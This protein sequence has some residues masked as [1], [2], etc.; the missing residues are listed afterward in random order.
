[1][2]EHVLHCAGCNVRFR[3]KTYDPTKKYRCSKCKGVLKPDSS[4]TEAPD[5]QSLVSKPGEAPEPVDDKLVGQRISHYRLI[6]KLGQGGMGAVYQAENVNLKRTVALKI[7]PPEL[8]AANPQYAQ[9]FLR[10][11]QSQAALDHPNVV[12]IHHVGK[13]GDYYY[14][15]M[16]YVTGGNLAD[17][18]K[19]DHAVEVDRAVEIVRGAAA[20]L[21]AAHEEG[22]VHRDVKPENILLGKGDAP[23]V[24]DF[25]LAKQVE[26]ESGLTQS[27]TVLGTPYYMSPEQ[28]EA[29]PVDAR[30][31]IYSLG[32]TLYHLLTG[33]QPFRAGSAV[34]IMYKHCEEA[35][36]A[37]TKQSQ[38][39]FFMRLLRC[40]TAP[41]NE[42][43]LYKL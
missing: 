13:E 20:G 4:A 19:G 16:Q 34:A 29:K 9:R 11:A 25:G 32:V 24:S 17:L 3:V 42:F 35:P 33:Q 5:A 37:P 2:A 22:L 14:I 8:S 30:S 43:G 7:L 27:G 26:L 31:D 41:R 36:K 15:E 6:K 23:K 39:L 10:E 18:L 38:Y 21:A 40:L 1:M 28:C 12:S